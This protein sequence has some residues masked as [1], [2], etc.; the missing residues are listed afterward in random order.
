[1]GF[2]NA[3]RELGELSSA[4]GWESYLKFP[5]GQ[6]KENKK[7]EIPKVLRIWLEVYNPDAL[8]LRVHGVK[9]MDLVDYM[10]DPE[11]KKKY[12][13][14]DRVGKNTFWGFTPLHLMG[15]PKKDENA[16]K[17]QLVG[18]SGDWENEKDCIFYKIK[19]RLLNDYE[20]CEFFTPGAVDIIMNFLNEHVN[21]IAD[22]YHGKGT[23]MLLFGIEDNGNFR[24]PGDVPAFVKYFREKLEQHIQKKG[25][26][27][28]ARVACSCC[29]KI[30]NN[31][32]ALDKVFKFSTFDKVNVLPGLD[33]RNIYKVIPVCQECLEKLTA[34]REVIE[35]ELTDK[36]TIQGINI[37]M[38]PE[39]V[40]ILRD[41]EL[42][43][44]TIKRLNVNDE[45]ARG[46]GKEGERKFFR[47]LAKEDSGLVFHFLFWETLQAQ[48]RVHLMVEDVPPSLLA[49]LEKAWQ[50]ALTACGNQ[51]KKD[52]DSAFKT[53]FAACI[54]L[55]GKSTE[56]KA[57]MRDYVINIIGRMLRGERLTVDSFKT[58]FVRRIPKLLFDSDKWMNVRSAASRGQLVV[59]FMERI[60]KEVAKDEAELGVS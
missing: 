15:K 38:V 52:L 58:M 31:P 1:V 17:K 42:L 25:G 51:S 53:I 26:D 41:S 10:I 23:F 44:R 57:V 29:H 9:K 5:L 32:V 60:N 4:S 47:R 37:W 33:K 18:E 16:R 22:L 30:T 39:V 13:Y 3:V 35:R 49:R 14:R 19:Y 7:D 59:E 8:Q 36:S 21:D 43:R 34:G 56:D 55:S 50:K 11:M 12:L 2:L 28:S 20:A 40:G 27:S 46:M 45:G 54:S 48:E 6:I 24:Y